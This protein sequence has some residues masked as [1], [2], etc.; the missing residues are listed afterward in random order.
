MVRGDARRIYCC[1]F[2]WYRAR[3]EGEKVGVL[4]Q[5]FLLVVFCCWTVVERGEEERRREEKAQDSAS[6]GGTFPGLQYRCM[7]LSV[8]GNRP[9]L[10][11]PCGNQQQNHPMLPPLRRVDV[12]S[13]HG[14][15]Q[16]ATPKH[17]IPMHV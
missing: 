13:P 1:V 16:N 17:V 5:A 3:N 2:R 11:C 12:A 6:L 8:I 7:L 4:E 10:A 14:C 15:Q 9:I